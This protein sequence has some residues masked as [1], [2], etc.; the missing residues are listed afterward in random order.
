MVWSAVVWG[1]VP[2]AC[3][4]GAAA[5]R[6]RSTPAAS[7]RVEGAAPRR[8][9]PRLLEPRLSHGAGGL[10]SC[11]R[12]R[13]CSPLLWLVLRLLHDSWTVG[14]FGGGCGV[15]P[16][17]RSPLAAEERRAGGPGTARPPAEG[18]ATVAAGATI[19]VATPRVPPRQYR[20]RAYPFPFYFRRRHSGRH[21]RRAVAAAPALLSRFSHRRYHL[22]FPLTLRFSCLVRRPHWRPV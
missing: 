18:T 13:F 2:C 9:P 20:H 8:R 12:R 11:R 19:F 14:A 1:S 10:G 22:F 21:C 5:R 3:L 7:A 17:V 16:P 15:R 6:P 4:P